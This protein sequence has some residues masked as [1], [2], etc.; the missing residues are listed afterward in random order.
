MNEIRPQ[1]IRSSRA[2]DLQPWHAEYSQALSTGNAEAANRVIEDLL[3]RRS[4]LVDIYSQVITPSLVSVGDLWCRKDISVAEEHL[5]T[6]LVL[7]HLDRLIEMFAWRDRLSSY[8]ILVGCV[9]GERHWVGA[10]MFADLC[11]SHGWS[12]EF[13]G[14]DVP[15]DALVDIVKKRNPQVVALSAA[16]AAGVEHARWLVRALADLANPPRIIIGGHAIVEHAAQQSFGA[17]CVIAR[18]VL[19]GLD[20]AQRFLRAHRPKVVLKEYLSAL[21]RRVRDLR[22]RK[23]WTQEQ[24]AESARVTRVCIVAVEGGKQ[25]VSMDIVV[26]LAN[27]LGVSPEALMSDDRETNQMSERTR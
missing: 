2:A 23:G 8:R 4:S 26:R 16:M 11:L 7:T 20:Y 6:Q 3:V 21:G 10:R 27:A 18:D 12:A 22:L 14:P 9:E 15:N 19:E 13:L 17:G 25:N 24:L 5:A 1:R